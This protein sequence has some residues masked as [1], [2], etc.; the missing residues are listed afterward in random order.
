MERDLLQA[1][2][3]KDRL[4]MIWSGEQVQVRI[5]QLESSLRG[6]KTLCAT[7]LHLRAYTEV[8]PAITPECSHRVSSRNLREGCSVMAHDVTAHMVQLDSMECWPGQCEVF[9]GHVMV[10]DGIAWL[11]TVQNLALHINNYHYQCTMAMVQCGE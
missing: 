4:E 11:H 9:A 2:L 3:E 8:L 7:A 6:L 1:E 5:I 10:L